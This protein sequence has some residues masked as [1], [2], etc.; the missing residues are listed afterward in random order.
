N[1]VEVGLVGALGLAHV[2][3]LDQRVDVGVLHV[4]RLIRCRVAG[5]VARGE[6]AH[7]VGELADLDDAAADILVE[8]GGEGGH[9]AAIGLGAGLGSGGIGIGDVLGDHPHAGGLRVHAG[10]GDLERGVEVHAC[11]PQACLPSA[12]RMI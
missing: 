6:V 1:D 3:G 9:A 7:V 12:V 8:H 2:H 4:P 11:L 10:G 5:L